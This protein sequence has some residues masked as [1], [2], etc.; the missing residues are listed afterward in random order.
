MLRT[1]F[2]FRSRNVKRDQTTI[3]RSLHINGGDSRIISM[4]MSK[5]GAL[6]NCV[7]P[8]RY[9]ADT[10]DD[11]INALRACQSIG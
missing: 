9:R 2:A 11:S 1:A 10:R 3:L 5:C 7:G 4:L 8:A 6:S